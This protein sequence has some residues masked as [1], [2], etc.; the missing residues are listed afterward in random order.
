MGRIIGG[1]K[2]A[3]SREVAAKELTLVYPVWQRNY[4]ERIIRNDRELDAIRGYIHDNPARW[5]HDPDHPKMHAPSRH[6]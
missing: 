3:V 4:H 5:T 1:F 6:L 2:S